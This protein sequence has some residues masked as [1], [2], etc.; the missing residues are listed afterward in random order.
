LGTAPSPS[1]RGTPT[2]PARSW[3]RQPGRPLEGV[4]RSPREAHGLG[5]LDHDL[6][7]IMRRAP[8]DSNGRPADS[9]SAARNVP[10][11]RDCSVGAGSRSKLYPA[12]VDRSGQEWTRGDSLRV[13]NRM[14]P[15]ELH[16]LFW[17]VDPALLDL[18]E[19]RRF[20][21]GRVLQKGRLADVRWLIRRY[22][23]AAI[24]EFFRSSGHPELSRRTLAFWR[25][26]FAA[27][28][29]KWQSPPSWR[30]S[31]AVPWPG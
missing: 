16:W 28:E 6:A 9:K 30:R 13:S 31:S 4:L 12:G 8:P 2:W 25:A 23:E 1:L 18:E 26:Y 7:G 3:L 21:L 17:D 29:E 15:T 20:I 19:H 14:L 22:G 5:G 24:H 27:Q 10:S 11:P